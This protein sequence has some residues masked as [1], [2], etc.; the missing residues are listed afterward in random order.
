MTAKRFE[1]RLNKNNIKFN[2]QNPVWDNEKQDAFNVFEMIDM[3]N[4]LHEENQDLHKKEVELGQ[5]YLK[6]LEENE[7]LRNIIKQKEE[8]EQLYAKEILRLNELNK[9]TNE[10]TDILGGY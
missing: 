2:T 6:L 5:N 4:H 1:N 3:L 7:Q 9:Q 10:F 8:E